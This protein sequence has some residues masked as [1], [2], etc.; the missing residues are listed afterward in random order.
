VSEVALRPL[1]D[2]DRLL[3]LVAMQGA[4]VRSVARPGWSS[5]LGSTPRIAAPL[6]LILSGD[7]RPLVSAGHDGMLVGEVRGLGDR[8]VWVLS[9][10]DAI[11]NH[12]LGDPANAAF[13]VALIDAL[14]RGGNVVF[15]EEVHGFARPPASALHLLFEFPFSVATAQGALAVLL[16][17][18]ATLGRFGAP[19]PAPPALGAGK[20]ALMENSARLLEFA[21]HQ[22]VIVRRYVEA[23]IREVA[24]QLHAPRGMPQEALLLWLGRVGKARGV[25]VDGADLHRRAGDAAGEGRGD[26]AELVSIVRETHQWKRGILDGG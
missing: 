16:L 25:A 21:G 7:L 6:Q 14:R 2:A 9:D 23:A 26:P 1:A 5:T 18:W 10:P 20:H 8:R 13:A 11:A 15:D 24:Q 17:L 3:R 4:V 19:E 12:A 22:R